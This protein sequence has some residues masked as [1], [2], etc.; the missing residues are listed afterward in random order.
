M[1]KPAK[2]PD[3]LQVDAGK[4][5]ISPPSGPIEYVVGIVLLSAPLLLVH[6]LLTAGFAGEKPRKSTELSASADVDVS[7]GSQTGEGSASEMPGRKPVSRLEP[8][9]A[10]VPPLCTPFL[11]G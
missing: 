1:P 11:T 3:D 8:L 6:E 5:A 4:C 9:S 7:S 10:P 2:L